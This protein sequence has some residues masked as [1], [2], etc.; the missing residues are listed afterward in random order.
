MLYFV[1]KHQS[2]LVM[3]L[4]GADLMGSDSAPAEVRVD[5]FFSGSEYAMLIGFA[6]KFSKKVYKTLLLCEESL[7]MPCIKKV[8]DVSEQG[9]DF[10][11]EGNQG[12]ATMKLTSMDGW[13]I[14]DA[15][16]NVK[17]LFSD[18]QKFLNT[19]GD[20]MPLAGSAYI[21]NLIQ[22]IS[23]DLYALFLTTDPTGVNHIR[24]KNLGQSLAAVSYHPIDG[25]PLFAIDSSFLKLSAGQQYFV[26]SH[27]L[28]HYVLQHHMVV[29]KINMP[30]LTTSSLN[31]ILFKDDVRF[32][33]NA[34]RRVNEYEADRFAILE[35]NASIADAI[36]LMEFVNIDFGFGLDD[37]EDPL[38]LTHPSP[39]KRMLYLNDL[40]RDLEAAR[41]SPKVS[42]DWHKIA[43]EYAVWSGMRGG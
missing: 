20:V 14:S 41:R 13:D 9:I 19:Y 27:E 36:S 31:K 43:D 39:E 34:W 35:F 23:P 16:N 32:F 29:K 1:K 26:I 24:L 22:L 12:Y 2:L 6:E 5:N 17:A 33:E 37:Q 18:Y 15:E 42:I 25:L 38:L 3:L 10:P 21:L 11:Q 4:L 30:G 28:A 7:G 40:E 8:S